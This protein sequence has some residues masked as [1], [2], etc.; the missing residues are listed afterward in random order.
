VTSAPPSARRCAVLI[1]GAGSRAGGDK[2]LLPLAGRPLA[3]WVLDAAR[4]A[5]LEPVLIAKPETPLGELAAGAVVSESGGGAPAGAAE[6]S[7]PTALVIREPAEPLHPL[8]GIAAALSELDEPLVVCPCDAPRVSATVLAA[9]AGAPATVAT[10][11]RGPEPLLGRYEPA[12]ADALRRLARDGRAAREAV[13]ALD[14]AT[15]AVPDSQLANVNTRA[16]L[17]SLE[18]ELRP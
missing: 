7:E 17:L 13:E 2:H 8:V 11:S 4:E 9:L 14:L 18:A 16:E 3:A 1:G 12:M 10:G 5:G 6:P 15:L